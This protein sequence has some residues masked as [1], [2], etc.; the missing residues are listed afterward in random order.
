[1]SEEAKPQAAVVP[2]AAADPLPVPDAVAPSDAK[3]DTNGAVPNGAPEV[4]SEA[5]EVA[6]PEAQDAPAPAECRFPIKL[7]CHFHLLIQFF[8]CSATNQHELTD[9][10]NTPEDVTQDRIAPPPE[11]TEMADSTKYDDDDAAPAADGSAEPAPTTPASAGKA[12]PRRKSGGIPEHKGKKL[13]K[14]A[15]K[16]KMTHTDAKP[17]DYFY[18]RLKGYPLW[19]AIV[20]DESM[21]PNTLI[22]TRPVTAAKKDG[23]YRDDFADSGPKVK[24]RSFPVMYMHT[25]EL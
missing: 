1:M 23:T 11:D 15:S 5:K 8:S 2:P 10:Q 21:L 20:C 19:P 18:V 13:N 17:G 7:S 25:N 22:K 14:K 24:D 3:A 9:K 4:A 12:K 6:I 16:A